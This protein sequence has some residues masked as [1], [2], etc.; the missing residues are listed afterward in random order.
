MNELNLKWLDNKPKMK[1]G[2]TW[3]IPW[4]KGELSQ[5]KFSQSEILVANQLTQKKVLAYWPDG[6]VKWTSHSAIFDV[7]EEV[8]QVSLEATTKSEIKFIA[9][10]KFNGIFV[11]NGI[12]QV[13]FPK[14]GEGKN[15]IDYVKVNE[16]YSLKN[17]RLVSVFD[18]VPMTFQLTNVEIED[19]GPIKAVIRCDLNLFDHIGNVLQSVTIRFKFYSQLSKFEIQYTLFIHSDKCCD[20]V[21]LFFDVPLEGENWNRQIKFVGE[22]QVYCEASQLLI[23]RRHYEKNEAYEHQA[24][25]QIITLDESDSAMLSHA[26]KNAVWNNFWLNQVTASSFEIKKQTKEGYSRI[27]VGSGNRSKG[28]VYVGDGNGG[29]TI[30]IDKFWQK[31]PSGI[32]VVGLSE[33]SCT[34]KAWLWNPEAQPMEFHHYDSESHMLSAYEGMDEF[35]STPIG[36]ANTS[37]LF[38]NIAT[39]PASNNE[40]LAFAQENIHPAHIVCLPQDYKNSHVFGTYSLPNE[41]NSYLEDQMKVLREFYFD[42]VEQRNWYGYWNFGDVM[43]TY[44]KYRHQWRY[45]LGGYAWQNTELVP[46]IWLWLEFLR[47]GD[48]KTYYFAEAMTRH[49]SEVDQYHFGEYKGLGSRHNVMHWGCQAKEAR[50]S[51]AGLHRYYYYLSGGDERIGEI[52]EQ[53][54]D[55]EYSLKNLPPMR[56]FYNVE[57]EDIIPIRTGPDWAALVSNWF[58]QWERTGDKKYLN[59][60]LTGI[61]SIKK[62]PDRLL[63]GPTVLMNMETKELSYMGTGNDGGY[64]MIIS[65]GAPQVWLELAE[66]INDEQW[67]AMLAEFGW[68]YSLSNEEKI[69]ESGTKLNDK[70]FAWPMFATTMMAYADTDYHTRN[71]VNELLVNSNLSGI[72][73]PVE[74]TINTVETY[75][76]IKEMPWISTNVVS[77][78][79]LNLICSQGYLSEGLEAKNDG[80]D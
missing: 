30:Q 27:K 55:N 79:C 50:I 77:Q 12:F 66:N 10:E 67:N 57:D 58:T 13:F 64:H 17:L 7:N 80:S 44:D 20:G 47:S 73:L 1:T 72:P 46:N 15:S 21:G 11:E 39:K 25:G 16:K 14:H 68:F 54:K 5:E 62:M 41:T 23:S 59:K 52:L 33:R 2:V 69:K 3:G 34:M 35:R 37:S 38:V 49:T 60:I 4:N 45:D 40:I 48:A 61:D 8:N 31:Y 63:S 6:S 19:N 22:D 65:F 51:M 42:E 78:W 53:V 32:E 29:V 18:K 71:R 9:N 74:K 76:T 24:K 36:I 26:K 43:H 28:A 56:E 75:K 70:H